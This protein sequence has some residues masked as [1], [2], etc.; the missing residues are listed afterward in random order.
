MNDRP[1]P[2]VAVIKGGRSS[3]H[4]ISLL[5]GEAV[6]GALEEAGFV[7]TVI[8]V[9]RDGRWFGEEGEMSLTPGNGIPGVDVAFPVLHGPFGEDGVTQGALETVGIPY[10]GSD[11][12]GSA[13]CMDKLTLKR[14]CLSQGIEQVE[15]V[16][17][18]IGDWREEALSFG[19]P[20][21]VKPSR[22]GSSVGISRVDSA[23]GLDRAVALASEHDPR[24]IIEAHCDGRE[25]EC[26]VLG[27]ERPEVSVP[28]EIVVSDGWYDFDSKYSE[29]GMDLIAPADLAETTAAEIR[30]RAIEVFRL[31][32]C[33]G[34]ARCDFFLTGAGE[35]LLNEVN[36]TPGFTAMS[37]YARLWAASGVGYPEL[38]GRLV[39]LA[40]EYRRENESHSF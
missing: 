23:A 27:N 36:T 9:S 28:G 12:L 19:L 1:K 8:E 33:S 10:V 32:G 31:A 29:G 5:S 6:A 40:F 20:L 25:I 7:V 35:V 39:T 16:Q 38:C 26:S 4:E 24:V 2:V 3:E 15:F 22:L 21:W 14:L 30:E 11:V 37:V 18:G 17:A 13:V 34:M